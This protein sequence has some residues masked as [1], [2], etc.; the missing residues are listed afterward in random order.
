MSGYSPGFRPKLN[1]LSV[2]SGNFKAETIKIHSH[3]LY[4]NETGH[5][6]LMLVVSPSLLLPVGH[7]HSYVPHAGLL[8]QI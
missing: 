3:E 5:Y 4:T 6:I 1:I 2:W 8:S 7:T